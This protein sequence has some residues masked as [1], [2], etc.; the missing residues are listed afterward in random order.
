M[1]AQERLIRK[2]AAESREILEDHEA[3]RCGNSRRTPCNCYDRYMRKRCGYRKAGGEYFEP[4]RL[5][6]IDYIL[7]KQGRGRREGRS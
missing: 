6:R 1:D 3:G 7:P 4:N 2:F 5:T